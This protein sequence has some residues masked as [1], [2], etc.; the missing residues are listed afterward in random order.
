MSSQLVVSQVTAEPQLIAGET[1]TLYVEISNPP[2]APA[3]TVEG[4]EVVIPPK[5]D[6]TEELTD[7]VAAIQP[8]GP[9][10]WSATNGPAFQFTPPGAGGTFAFDPDVTLTF[11]LSQVKVNQS[12]GNVRITIR[13]ANTETLNVSR[14]VTKLPSTFTVG[15]LTANPVTTINYPGSTILSWVGSSQSEFSPSYTLKWIQNSEPVN[16]PNLPAVETGF[17][18]SGLTD[19]STTFTL[20]V[21]Y[22]V[23]EQLHHLSRQTTVSVPVPTDPPDITCFTGSINPTV[24]GPPQATFEWS[25]TPSYL[26]VPTC[27]LSVDP[28]V[29]LEANSPIGGKTITSPGI[30]FGVT[31]TAT[32][33]FGHACK[34]LPPHWEVSA[35]QPIP[36]AASPDGAPYQVRLSNSGKL[37]YLT[38]TGGISVFQATGQ[39][40]TPWQFLAFHP[41]GNS[42]F[43]TIIDVAISPDDSMLYVA[44]VTDNIPNYQGVQAFDASAFAPHGQL[45]KTDVIPRK[46]VINKQGDLLYVV[47]DNP[48]IDIISVT[49][50]SSSPLSKYGATTSDLSALS[51]VA[52]NPSANELWVFGNTDRSGE[53]EIFTITGTSSAPLH[54][55]RSLPFKY[56]QLYGMAFSPSGESLMALGGSTL[57]LTSELGLYSTEDLTALNTMLEI[58][59]ASSLSVGPASPDIYLSGLGLFGAMNLTAVSTTQFFD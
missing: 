19:P 37:L 20:Y 5:G 48:Q 56:H 40:A 28:G 50:D 11:R 55:V 47:L 53:F 33:H 45:F 30:N 34:F 51:V 1:V 38:V 7:D 52:L 10:G 44:L 25:A 2:T 32:N 41:I 58:K 15:P 17:P 57:S 43:T 4:F 23:D 46:I 36:Q 9:T 26:H 42:S 18:V 29:V 35:N 3:L 13:A 8:I 6:H 31:L 14:I 54:K 49:Q 24:S 22:T 12:A 27:E 21:E 59:N 16:K 39:S